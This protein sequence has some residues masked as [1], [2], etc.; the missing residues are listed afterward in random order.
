[1]SLLGCGSS[2]LDLEFD[3]DAEM[4][5]PVSVALAQ[6]PSQRPIVSP[7]VLT[8]TGSTTG[9]IPEK[10]V[11]ARISGS[12]L[13]VTLV[14]LADVTGTVIRDTIVPGKYVGTITLGTVTV[15]I[16]ATFT[17]YCAD[18]TDDASGCC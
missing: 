18:E 8:S 7:L 3:H 2:T 11:V 10:N 9:T 14:N 13:T 17:G 16:T 1:M 6:P 12:T 15:P 4:A 5:G